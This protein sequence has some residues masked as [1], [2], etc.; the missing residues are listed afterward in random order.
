[1]A[2]PLLD[3]FAEDQAHEQLLRA[4]I[5]RLAAEEGQAVTVRVRRARGGHGRVLEELKRYQ[6]AVEEG[7]V[8][9]PDLIVVAI[10]ANCQGSEARQSIQAKILPRFEGAVVIACP[11]PHIERWYMADVVSFQKVV[12]R[13]PKLEKMKCERDRYK[14]ILAQAIRDSGQIPTL[15]GI[16]FAPELVEAMDLYRAGKSEP[17]LKAFVEALRGAL[18][19]LPR[20]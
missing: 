18:R 14:Q 6:K 15:G 5:D 2:E 20:L 3:L 19:R 11:D 16:E 9:W 4:L 13:Q 7:V 8:G 1:M 10:D 17:S 12:G